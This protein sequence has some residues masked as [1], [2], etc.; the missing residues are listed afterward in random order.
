MEEMDCRGEFS[1]EAAP[2]FSLETECS[3]ATTTPEGL[4]QNGSWKIQLP[5]IVFS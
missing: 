4:F 3:G 2:D 1:D 5:S